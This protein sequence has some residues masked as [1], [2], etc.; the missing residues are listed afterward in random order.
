M[1]IYIKSR[2]NILIHTCA[3]CR[4]TRGF[5]YPRPMSRDCMHGH[6]LSAANSN[7]M[8]AS[9][10]DECPSERIFALILAWFELVT[11]V[12][13]RST[14][15]G[16][17]WCDTVWDLR[18]QRIKSCGSLQLYANTSRYHSDPGHF[19]TKANTRYYGSRTVARIEEEHCASHR[20]HTCVK[21]KGTSSFC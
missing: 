18:F 4:S 11:K 8:I 2:Y 9:I 14:S 13:C 12:L 16:A 20:V 17:S 19:A 15:Q 5:R 1:L 10:R 3:R 6:T 7:Q 21:Y